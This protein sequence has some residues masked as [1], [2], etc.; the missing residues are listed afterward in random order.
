MSKCSVEVSH[1]IITN[2]KEEFT[3]ESGETRK[4]HRKSKVHL[5]SFDKTMDFD[6]FFDE[7]CWINDE[8]SDII[9]HIWQNA[10]GISLYLTKNPM[11]T[12]LSF[13]IGTDPGWPKK[14]YCIE[15]YHRRNDLKEVGTTED[16]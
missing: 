2:F 11:H 9:Q 15:F 4:V 1:Y 16:K 12:A 6:K 7:I 13:K 14:F 3:D 8:I 5:E 10:P